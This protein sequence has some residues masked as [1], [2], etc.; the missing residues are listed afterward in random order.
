MKRS[1][2]EAVLPNA[3]LSHQRLCAIAVSRIQAKSTFPDQNDVETLCTIRGR[4]HF[5]RLRQIVSSVRCHLSAPCTPVQH[6]E[7]REHCGVLI[8]LCD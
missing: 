1:T 8:G 5:C 6:G 2:P 4:I 7:V 3:A